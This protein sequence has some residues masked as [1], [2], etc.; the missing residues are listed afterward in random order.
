MIK[1]HSLLVLIFLCASYFGFGQGS[2]SFENNTATPGG[3]T[4]GSYVG[5]NGVT[6]TYNQ[7]RTVTAIDNITSTSIGFSTSGTRNI[8]ASSGANGVGDI[9]YSVSSYFTGGSAANRSIEV[10]V[11]GI[12]YD[13]Y[14]LLAMSTVYTRNFTANEVGNVLIELRSSGSR[15]IVLDD[16]S[17]T[18]AS[19]DDIDWCNIQDP[20]TSPQ[21]ID[22][23]NSFLV[24]AQGW[25]TGVTDSPGQGSG[26]LAWI[27]YSSTNNNPAI[28][29]GWTWEP[30]TFN[31][32]DGNNDEFVADL[33]DAI[34]SIGT[35][36]Y[37]SRF[38]LNGGPYTYGG[39]GGV[40]NSDS[41]LLNVNART[42]DWCNLQSPNIGTI[43]LGNVYNVF[44]QIYETGITEN[45]PVTPGANILA[46]I[47]YSTTDNNPSKWWLDLDTCCS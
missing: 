25:E 35:Y 27:G 47:G 9:T 23:G 3:Y 34:S 16:V 10:Y 2:E 46:W 1:K 32:D 40:W 36:Y 5:D 13:S 42:L 43:S 12:L 30:A 28:S 33:G 19:T 18:A 7:A 29:S 44:A 15:Q 22:L 4:N 37:A 26:V 21:N 24:Y 20:N 39:T 45:S 6:W 38:Q 14:T 8:S 11:N 17:W 41:V 31:T